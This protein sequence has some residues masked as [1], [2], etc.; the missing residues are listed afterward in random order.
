MVNDGYA[1]KKLLWVWN[2]NEA[3]I[4]IIPEIQYN[5]M[6]FIEHQ[7]GQFQLAQITNS[8]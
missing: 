6:Y 1:G 8:G 2:C 4:S 5:T 7:T 3:D